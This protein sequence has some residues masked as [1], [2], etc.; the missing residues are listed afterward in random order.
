MKWTKN[1]I[2][3]LKNNP[4][5]D[6]TEFKSKLLNRTPL[7]I[8]QQ[9]LKLGLKYS[10]MKWLNYELDIIQNNNY[11]D[12]YI[13]NKLL[14]Y[15]RLSAIIDKRH[16]LNKR[17]K[18]KCD[19]CGEEFVVVNQHNSCPGCT[20][21]Y[22][23]KYNNSIKGI[24]GQYKS[25]AKKR[26][27]E[28][29]LTL[30]FFIKNNNS[31]CYYCGDKLDKIGFDRVDNSIGYI[32][33]NVVVCCKYCNEMKKNYNTDFWTNKMKQILNNMRYKDEN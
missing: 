13:S 8:Q 5:L 21:Q 14:N 6:S 9:R 31:K 26:N 27:L 1:E 4:L 3:T 10:G 33:D 30:D 29:K 16:K 28:F 20:S 23:E 12:E 18:S 19:V 11:T 15:R 2:E 7:A 17:L 32:E 24:Y 25:S 22:H